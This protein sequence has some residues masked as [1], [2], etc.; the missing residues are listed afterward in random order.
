MRLLAPHEEPGAASHIAEQ[1]DLIGRLTD[2]GHAYQAKDGSVYFSVKSFSGYG[3]LTHLDQRE[4][5]MGAAQSANDADE[6]EK[7]SVADFA[8]WKA[9]KPEDGSNFWESPWGEGRPGWHLECSAM[10]LKY[11]GDSFDLHGGGVDLCFPHHENEIAQSEAA[12]GKGFVGHWFHSE[13]LAVEGAK[14]S[15]SLGN[16]YTLEDIPREGVHG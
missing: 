16:L 5:R 8:L 11:L 1:I 6:Y 2:R 4:L 7:D 15:K 3:K 14:M 13:H 12:T 10:G 9:R